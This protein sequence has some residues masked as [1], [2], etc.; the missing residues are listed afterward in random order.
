MDLFNATCLGLHPNIAGKPDIDY[1]T[2]LPQ[3]VVCDVVF[4]PVDP[5]FLQEVRMQ[6]ARTVSGIGMPVQQGALAFTLWTGKEA[7]EQVMYDTLAKEFLE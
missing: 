5:L 2:I 3:M 1:C 6:G 7:P 4:N